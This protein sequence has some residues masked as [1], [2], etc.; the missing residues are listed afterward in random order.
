MNNR[1]FERSLPEAG[2]HL[3][4]KKGW[5]SYTHLDAWMLFFLFLLSAFGLFV[6]YSASGQDVDYVLRQAVRIGA[7]FVVLIILAQFTP[8]LLARWAPWVY[9]AGV[10]LLVAVILFGVG[11]KGAQRWIALPGFR[12]QPAEVMKLILPLM[13][14]CYLA[15]RSLPPSF[16]HCFISLLLI[17]VPT[18]LIMK[19][20]DLGTSLLIAASGV[21]VLLFSGIRWHYIMGALAVAGAALP[22]LWMVMKDYQRQRVLTFLD[23]ESDPLGAGWNIIQSKT[24]IG[25]G[26]IWGKGWLSGTQSQLDF[27]PES[28]TD[29]IIAVIAEELGLIGISILL[30][31]YILIIGRGL[32]MATRVSDCFG[33]LVAASIVLTFFVYVFVNIGMVSGLLPVVGVPLPFVS[34]G[35]TSVVTLMAGFGILMS[36]Y[37]HKQMTLR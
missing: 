23:P 15:G 7:G 19:Q 28:H 4:R 25:S 20:P 32:W 1:D 9:A 37:S 11:A 3:R 12:F 33:K 2:H 14:A 34:Y 22:G 5:W 17:G 29:F 10:V 36:V 35:G 16:K 8:R 31:M 6:L 24:A 13:V 27:L 26:G 21:F 30:V 18:V